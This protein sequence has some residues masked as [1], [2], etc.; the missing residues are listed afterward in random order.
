MDGERP[1]EISA[2]DERV[3]GG[4][5]TALDNIPTATDT[6]RDELKWVIFEFGA[7]GEERTTI[8]ARLAAG[9]ISP[10]E[11]DTRLSAIADQLRTTL[12]AALRDT[13]QMLG[14]DTEEEEQEEPEEW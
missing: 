14:D 13:R 6:L 1:V 9:E 4:D 3:L 11:A 7:L 5:M 2:L 12:H 10:T 8:E